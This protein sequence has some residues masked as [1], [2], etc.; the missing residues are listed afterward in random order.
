MGVAWYIYR[1]LCNAGSGT[2]SPFRTVSET[3]ARPLVIDL[4]SSTV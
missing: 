3:L 1:N 2:G 4:H